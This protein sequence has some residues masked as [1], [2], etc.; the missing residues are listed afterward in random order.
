MT[1]FSFSLLASFSHILTKSIFPLAHTNLEYKSKVETSQL[2]K[3][4]YVH[5]IGFKLHGV[6]TQSLAEYLTFRVFILKCMWQNS[7][8]V[9]PITKIALY[10]YCIIVVEKI[11]NSIS[12]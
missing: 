3:Y 2:W 4:D 6:D 12:W 5:A 11:Y 7:S 1:K 10:Q 8:R 9:E